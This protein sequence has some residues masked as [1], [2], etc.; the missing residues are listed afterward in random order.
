M[1]IITLNT[2]G[3]RAGESLKA[4]FEAHASDVDVFCL[5]EIFKGAGNE[6]LQ[7]VTSNPKVNPQLFEMVASALPNHEGIFCPVYKD[8]YGIACFVKKGIEVVNQGDIQLTEGVN[9]LDPEY[10]GSDHARKMQWL[11][12]K[13]GDRSVFVTNIHGHWAP[14]DKSDSDESI[15]QIATIFE[16]L[17]NH[18]EP[19]ILCGDFNLHPNTKSIQ[20]LD[21]QFRNLI[22]ENGITSTRTS[23]FHWPQKFADYIFVSRDLEV[24]SFSVLPDEISDHAP[25]MVEIE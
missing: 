12:L 18:D 11:E 7:D 10:P 16:L 3:G 13:D 15:K 2:W 9:Y 19:K 5:Q 8:A 4:F 14:G 21:E 6:V 23:L 17:K 20:M 22:T 24:K 25:L 1:K